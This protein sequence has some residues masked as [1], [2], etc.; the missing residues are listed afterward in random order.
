MKAK[1]PENITAYEENQK[2]NNVEVILTPGHT[3]GMFVFFI[4]M[5]FLR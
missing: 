2:I 5:I 3:T 4:R 1:K